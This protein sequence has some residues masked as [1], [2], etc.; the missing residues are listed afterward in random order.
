[1]Q[2]HLLEKMY[3]T[4]MRIYRGFGHETSENFVKI[5][6]IF[7]KNEEKSRNSVQNRR[8]LS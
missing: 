4:G 8:F 1:M 6:P 2:M 3:F 5:S 7:T